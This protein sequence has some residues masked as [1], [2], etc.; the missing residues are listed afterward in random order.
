MKRAT[1][2]IFNNFG[3]INF[4]DMKSNITNLI[5]E[6]KVCLFMKGSP[7]APQWFQ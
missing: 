6:H 3:G 7:D 2:F 1:S 4:M 5:N